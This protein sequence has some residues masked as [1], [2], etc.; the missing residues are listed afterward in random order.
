MCNK[1]PK[2]AVSEAVFEKLFVFRKILAAA[3]VFFIFSH[4]LMSFYVPSGSMIPTLSVGETVIASK[5]HGYT[6]IHRQ[7]IVAFNPFTPANNYL[8]TAESERNILY[9][10]RVIGL[11]G[12]TV[13]ISDG[14]LYVNGIPQEEDYLPL[15]LIMKD[16]PQVVVPEGCYFM[17]GDN[18]NH[19]EDSRVIGFIPRENLV[20]KSLFHI[21]SLMGRWLL[22]T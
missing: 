18:R 5:I 15:G 11:P 8:G 22:S 12:D 9:I 2:A 21:N 20:S 1:Q 13:E 4:F 10:K 16:Y 14:V 3:L 6:E 7:D 17:M 19:S